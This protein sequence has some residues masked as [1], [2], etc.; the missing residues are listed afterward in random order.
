MI[1][2][3]GSGISTGTL[4]FTLTRITD[5]KRRSDRRVSEDRVMDVT[6]EER[7]V[8]VLGGGGEVLA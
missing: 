4:A 7:E 1:R 2:R 8:C 6:E 5:T 3:L